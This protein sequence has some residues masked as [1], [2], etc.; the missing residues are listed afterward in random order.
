MDSHDESS[1]SISVPCGSAY[2][3][4]VAHNSISP[5][6]ED[7]GTRYDHS[8]VLHIGAIG[9]SIPLGGEFAQLKCL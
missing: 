9:W 3:K 1:K 2:G 6:T 7:T 5:S 4:S 8:F